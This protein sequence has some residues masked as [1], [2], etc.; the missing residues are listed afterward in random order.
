MSQL[1]RYLTLHVNS[2]F[3]T[4][5]PKL[6]AIINNP[7]DNYINSFLNE[8]ETNLSVFDP[9]T[10]IELHDLLMNLDVN[11]SSN[12]DKI[13]SRLFKCCLLS[14]VP[15]VLHLFNVTLS[16]CLIP[17]D[18]KIASITLVFKSGHRKYVSNYR[19]ISLL[20]VVGKLLE[21]LIHNR[22]Y[23]FLHET[24]FFCDNQCGFRPGRGTND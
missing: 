20:P 11:K 16:T 4:I 24:E 12:I 17:D 6:A 23:E 9:V 18:W 1:I 15:Q 22:I 10:H 14:T 19:P 3:T 8:S 7:N 5:G 21:K 13:N 2:Y